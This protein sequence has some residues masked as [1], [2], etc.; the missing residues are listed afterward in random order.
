M[1]LADWL[2]NLRVTYDA[3]YIIPLSFAIMMLSFATAGYI[4]TLVIGMKKADKNTNRVVEVLDRIASA[5]ENNH[6]QLE[7]NHDILENNNKKLDGLVNIFNKWD[8][9]KFWR[10]NR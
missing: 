9:T 5:I 3:L 1:W 10:W 7:K 8:W 4:L 6:K 2:Y